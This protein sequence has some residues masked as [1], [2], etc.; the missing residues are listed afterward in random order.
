MSRRFSAVIPAAG[1]GS[2]FG[3]ET[4]KQYLPLNGQPLIHHALQA[5]LAESR[6]EQI[7]VVLAPGDTRWSDRCLPVEGG[8]RIHVVH[9]GGATRADSVINGINWLKESLN[10]D[11]DDW[12]LVHDAARPC[13]DPVQLKSLIDTLAE[14]P[15]GGLLAIPVADTLKRADDS[16]RIE[17][18]VDRRGLWLAQTPQMFRVGQLQQALSGGDRVAMT[19]EA[20]AIERLGLKPRL[21][22]GS[23][24]N[25]KV[26]YPED[27]PLAEM[28]LAAN[29]RTRSKA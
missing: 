14:D 8:Q 19:D 15:V 24:T 25:L 1:T 12:L 26:T 10:V 16:G 20:S 27:L 28:I 6:I 23:L 22:P 3:T 7:V 4:P 18:T 17:A 11:D 29:S 2:R 5:L 9:A 13:L 21:V